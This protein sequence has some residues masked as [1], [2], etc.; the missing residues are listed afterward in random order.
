M[1]GQVA[2]DG[3]RILRMLYT[4][5]IDKHWWIDFGHYLWWNVSFCSL[6]RQLEPWFWLCN[7]GCIWNSRMYV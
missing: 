7:Y 4:G 5:E 2:A 3:R 1:N 6:C